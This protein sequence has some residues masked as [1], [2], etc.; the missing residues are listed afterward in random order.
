[1]RNHLGVSR[2]GISGKS[3]GSVTVET[4]HVAGRNG[5][6]IVI[7][8]GDYPRLSYDHTYTVLGINFHT[9]YG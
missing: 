5:L 6:L 3:T 4:I 9:E 2:G 7:L 1:M 8:S